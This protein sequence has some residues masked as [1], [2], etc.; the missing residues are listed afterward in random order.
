LQAYYKIKSQE[1]LTLT[2]PEYLLTCESA[3][4]F[5]ESQSIFYYERSKPKVLQVIEQEVITEHLEKLVKVID[6]Y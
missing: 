2:V 1:W 5:E 4:A 3:L 6:S